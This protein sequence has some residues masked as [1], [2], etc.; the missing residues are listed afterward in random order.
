MT[1]KQPGFW[2]IIQADRVRYFGPNPPG[3]RP[4][5]PLTGLLVADNSPSSAATPAGSDQAP[6]DKS[7]EAP[8]PGAPGDEFQVDRSVASTPGVAGPMGDSPIT[9]SY[10]P[11]V[12][13]L[14][15]APLDLPPLGNISSGGE[16]DAAGIDPSTAS[17]P[18]LV[19]SSTRSSKFAAAMSAAAN[20]SL[21]IGQA[22][23]ANAAKDVLP[24]LPDTDAP[25]L[26]NTSPQSPWPTGARA[27][28]QQG[29]AAGSGAESGA[30]AD[31]SSAA[32]GARQP[33]AITINLGAD[34][35]LAKTIL[36]SM[37]HK[38]ERLVFNHA[39]HEVERG[40]HM[41]QANLRALFRNFP[42]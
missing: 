30:S 34:H 33:L 10:V 39:R 28:G 15:P 2:E 20:R 3:N 36:E 37:S 21:A 12:G 7:S 5:D 22:I 42:S 41:Y 25:G 26:D 19:P 35:R 8:T 16:P 9:G 29:P 4:R 23:M 6:A 38:M 1:R 14:S 27:A 13:G 31:G 32:R 11:D 17:S 24:L 18:P 40:F